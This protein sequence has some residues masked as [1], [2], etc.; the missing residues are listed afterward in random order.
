MYKK[1]LSS[2]SRESVSS[3]FAYHCSLHKV[4]EVLVLHNSFY[5]KCIT[6]KVIQNLIQ[7]YDTGF[8]LFSDPIRSSCLR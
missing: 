1:A 8:N 5:N 4:F 3:V 6:E 2:E 7:N